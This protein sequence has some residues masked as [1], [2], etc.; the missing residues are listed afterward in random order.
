MNLYQNERKKKSWEG[1]ETVHDLNLATLSVKHR[2]GSV[3]SWACM[4]TSGTVHWLLINDVTVDESI[5][6]N[7]AVKMCETDTA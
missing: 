1:K 4:D 5:R 6:M 3:I 7:G 2:G